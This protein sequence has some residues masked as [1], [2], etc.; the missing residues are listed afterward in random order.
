LGEKVVF[1]KWGDNY[2]NKKMSL[3]TLENSTRAI[4]YDVIEKMRKIAKTNSN[5][6]K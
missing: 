6:K 5:K 1:L 4:K 3:G 2:P